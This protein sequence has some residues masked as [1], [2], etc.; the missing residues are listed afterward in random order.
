[1]FY[2]IHIIIS[3]LKVKKL[4]SKIPV[5]SLK[6]YLEIDF[7]SILA[8]LELGAD[9]NTRDLYGQTILHE[10]AREWHTDVAKFF[11]QNGGNVNLPDFYGRTALHVAAWADYAEMVEFLIENGAD[12]EAVTSHDGEKLVNC[13]VKVPGQLQT[14]LHFAAGSDSKA[15]C[16]VLIE[17]GANIEA[18]DYKNRTPLYIAAELDRSYS[19][20]YLIDENANATVKGF[21]QITIVPGI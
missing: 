8:I 5:R 6:N 21:Q 15:A 7:G 14:P 18:R 12:I 10:I 2:L 17:N 4:L 9:I 11:I 3:R 13:D 1:M 19:A 20:Q 16:K